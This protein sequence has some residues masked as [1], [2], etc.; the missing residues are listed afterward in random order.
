MKVLRWIKNNIDLKMWSV[1]LALLVWFHV[2]TERTYDMTY[3]ASLEF[4]NPPK[5]WT[6]VGNPP[7]EISLRLRGSGKQLISHR[8]YGEPIATLELPKRKSRRLKMDIRPEDVILSRKGKV[9][10]A[11]IVSPTQ[12]TIEMDVASKKQVPIE[13]VVEG[14]PRK[15]FVQ[16]G[17]AT[18]APSEVELTGGKNRIRRIVRL[19]TVAID[20]EG[21]SKSLERMVGVSLPD[22]AGYRAKPDSVLARVVIEKEVRKV[23]Q[24]LPIKA[25]NLSSS[26]SVEISPELAEVTLAGPESMLDSVDSTNVHVSLDLSGMNEGSHLIPPKITRPENFEVL[27]VEPELIQVN[28]K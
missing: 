2:A 19:K 22:G 13:T 8:L 14:Q 16:V 3:T 9:E 11:S 27:S 1:V 6:I 23:L 10:I 25:T 20:I 17:R 28:I 12:L 7:E 15:G 26:R 18:L 24:N 21:E 4:V 5:G